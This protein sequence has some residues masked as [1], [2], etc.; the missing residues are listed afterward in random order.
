M[1]WLIGGTSDSVSIVR[2]LIK[3][4]LDFIITVTTNT[5]TQLYQSISSQCQIFVGKL[6]PSEIPQF[7]TKHH[8]SLVIDAS[9]PFAVNISHT[10]IKHCQELPLPYLR[11]ER[12]NITQSTSISYISSLESLL[13]ENSPLYHKR[14]LL[15]IGAKFL[16]L[17]S[18]YHHL[19][20][21]YARILPYP[22]SI[23][24]AYEANFSCD[25]IIALRPPIS[26]E[27]EKALWQMWNID[28]VVSKAGGKAGG[29]DIKQKISQELNIPLIILERP[30]IDYPLVINSI[31]EVDT[32]LSCLP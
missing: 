4:Q 28:I 13:K 21:L 17:F 1:I 6:S 19:S 7:I 5:A 20:T 2:L 31:E 27:L 16:H 12:P 24:L 15:T 3:H 29:E 23:N 25:R 26:P 30:K 22:E 32:F 18:N 10:V 14:V 11:Y 9:H 8:I